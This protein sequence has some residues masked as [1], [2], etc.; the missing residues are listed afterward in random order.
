MADP[1]ERNIEGPPAQETRLS[2][3]DLGADCRC[4][5]AA[6]STLDKDLGNRLVERDQT[7]LKLIM[8]AKLNYP[9]LPFGDALVKAL[10]VG[11][12]DVAAQQKAMRDRGETAPPLGKMLVDAGLVT[13][14]Q[15][16]DALAEQ[17]R[18]KQQGQKPPLL[19]DLIVQQLRANVD[20]VLKEQ[21]RK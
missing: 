20:Q 19:G 6:E 21:K 11:K 4:E 17:G 14:K 12:E 10:E 16:D 13:Q 5:K 3:G 9:E 2:S 15:V 7:T 8:D 18:L 1:M